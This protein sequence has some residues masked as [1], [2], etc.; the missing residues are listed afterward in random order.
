M[1]LE[2][3]KSLPLAIFSSFNLET[4]ADV[5]QLKKQL[6]FLPVDHP[7]RKFLIFDSTNKILFW[8]DMAVISRD[9][10]FELMKNLYVNPDTAFLGKRGMIYFFKQNKIYVKTRW[11]EEF[12]SQNILHRMKTRKLK[13]II[14]K[15]ILAEGPIRHW[16]IDLIDFNNLISNVNWMTV[17][18]GIRKKARYILVVVDVFSK[19]LYL[20]GI[21]SKTPQDVWAELQLVLDSSSHLPDIIQHDRGNEFRGYLELELKR[22]FP[23]IKNIQSLAYKPQSQGHVERVNGTIKEYLRQHYFLTETTDFMQVLS[24]VERRINWAYHSSI[25]SHPAAIHV[26]LPQSITLPKTYSQFKKDFG[27]KNTNDR[28]ITKKYYGDYD[29]LTDEEKRFLSLEQLNKIAHAN[30]LH[31]KKAHIKVSKSEKYKSWVTPFLN[32]NLQT[33]PLFVLVSIESLHQRTH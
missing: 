26:R 25:E 6:D 1:I 30:W 17:P 20:R 31:I 18:D 7:V 12:L 5:M 15:P 13:N 28:L 29:K 19:Y 23:T 8:K 11:I 21:P 4:D 27:V 14:V 3:F 9:Y 2:D 33:D 10:A 16:Q 24:A 32:R 22:R